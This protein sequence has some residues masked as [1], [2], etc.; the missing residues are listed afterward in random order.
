MNGKFEFQFEKL[1][2]LKKGEEGLPAKT[3]TTQKNKKDGTVIPSHFS[4]NSMYFIEPNTLLKTQ[5]YIPKC[6]D[7]FTVLHTLK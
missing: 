1:N 2:R 7:D 3:V 6:T 4:D 5:L